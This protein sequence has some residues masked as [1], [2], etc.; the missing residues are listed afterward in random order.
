MYNV[1]SIA[2]VV[3]DFSGSFFHVMFGFGILVV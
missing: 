2:P 3:T 1:F